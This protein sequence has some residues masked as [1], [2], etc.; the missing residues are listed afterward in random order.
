MLFRSK[1][2]LQLSFEAFNV[3]NFKNVIIGP[4]S[5]NNTNTIYGLG[6][7]ADG[8][9]A[10]VRTDALGPTFMRLK[11]PDGLYD[12]NDFQLGVPFQAQFG[13]RFFF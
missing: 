13:V 6:I 11:R 10:P 3:F 9:T 8:S 4:A 7:S 1:A 12:T 5:I 2:R